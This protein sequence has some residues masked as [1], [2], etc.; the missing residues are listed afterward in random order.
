MKKA[1]IWIIIL[2]FITAII[3]LSLMG[4]KLFDGDYNITAEAYI[5]LACMV[6]ITGC[7]FSRLFTDKCPHCGKLRASNGKFCPH[8]GKEL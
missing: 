1:R 7:A 4:L 5:T 8:C 6:V 2:A 3:A